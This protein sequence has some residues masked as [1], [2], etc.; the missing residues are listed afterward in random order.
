[1]SVATTREKFHVYKGIRMPS[2][3]TLLVRCLLQ[4]LLSE[5]LRKLL[6]HLTIIESCFLLEMMWI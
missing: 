4:K 6:I 5:L 1:M 3:A 2:P